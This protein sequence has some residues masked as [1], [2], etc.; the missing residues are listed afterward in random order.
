MLIRLASANLILV[1]PGEL[2]TDTRWDDQVA[3]IDRVLDLALGVP[4]DRDLGIARQPVEQDVRHEEGVFTLDHLRAASILEG[5]ELAKGHLSTRGR[6]NEDVAKR[7]GLVA[8]FAEITNAHGVSL[9]SLDCHGQRFA[10]DGDLDDL[11]HRGNCEAIAG[12]L[13]SIDIDLKVRFAHNAIGEDRRGLDT[14]N[15]LEQPF[16]FKAEGFDGLKIRTV[17]LDA[18]RCTKAR[19]EHDDARLDG[20]ELR[21]G[22]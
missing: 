18:H 1:R 6:W 20:L 10:A 17:D 22:W 15:P 21:C 7:L 5:A 9:S 8:Q 14:R 2:V 19:L 3:R 4:Y 13:L 11:L 16:E 12:D